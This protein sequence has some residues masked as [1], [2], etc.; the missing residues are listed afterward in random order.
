MRKTF[1]IGIITILLIVIVVAIIFT[2]VNNRSPIEN[3]D[4]IK[5][6][7]YLSTLSADELLKEYFEL[8]NEKN[9]QKAPFL[10]YWYKP[11][12]KPNFRN[13]KN[14]RLIS[15]EEVDVLEDIYQV[16]LEQNIIT[17]KSQVKQFKVEYWVEY[18]LPGPQNNGEHTWQYILVYHEG[19]WKIYDSGEWLG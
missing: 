17:D 13:L 8:Q 10:S 2:F 14:M 6:K 16:L 15:M 1:L 9:V 19:Q 11:G 4:A 5:Y 12:V 7:E 18:V 3:F